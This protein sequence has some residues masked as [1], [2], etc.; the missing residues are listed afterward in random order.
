[1]SS[2]HRVGILIGEAALSTFRLDK[3]RERLQAVMVV[4]DLQARFVYFVQASKPLTKQDSH[5]LGTL[6]EGAVVHPGATHTG[7][8]LMV[9]PRVG[10]ISPWSSK[11]TDIARH[12]GLRHV[13]RLERGIQYQLGGSG[14]AD[15]AWSAAFPLLADPMTQTVHVGTLADAAARLF[16]HAPVA[17]PLQR[18]AA[19]TE[20]LAQVNGAWGLALA[21]DE[22][23]YLVQFYQ[24]AGRDATDV[25]LMMF[26]Q[27]N[28]EHCRHKIFNAS[29]TIDG[30]AQPHSLFAMIRN[31]HAKSPKGTLV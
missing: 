16:Q 31:T 12:C 24:A 22:M 18:V 14:A 21:E 15:P 26:A 8:S 20:A 25:E 6:L 17:R 10:M 13:V 27:A 30:T 7:A 23:R 28:S 2:D 1:M 4:E 19:T 3:L 11:A 29:W 5:L 9:T